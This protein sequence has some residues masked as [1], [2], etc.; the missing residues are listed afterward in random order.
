MKKRYFLLCGMM[1]MMLSISAC[2]GKPQETTAQETI[3]QETKAQETKGAQTT[4]AHD[5]TTAEAPEETEKESTDGEAAEDMDEDTEEESVS[6][7]TKER[8]TKYFDLLLSENGINKDD[9]YVEYGG[10]KYWYDE[11]D[12]LYDAAEEAGGTIDVSLMGEAE[13][14]LDLEI[15][16]NYLDFMSDWDAGSSDESISKELIDRFYG[17]WHGVVRFKDCTGKYADSLGAD[18]DWVTSIARFWIDTDGYVVPF[19]GVHVEDTPIENLE[20]TLDPEDDCMYLSGS[21]INVDFDYVPMTEK[22]GTLHAEIPI[23]KDAGSFTMVFNLRHLNDIGWT[24]EDPALPRDYIENCQGWSF[25]KLAE[26][27]GYTSYDYPSY[28]EGEEPEYPVQ[29]V[30]EEAKQDTGKSTAEADGVVSLST[31]EAAYKWLDGELD[32]SGHDPITYEAVRDHMGVDGKI[33]KSSQWTAEKH[34]YE[35]TT[36]DGKKYLSVTFTVGADGSEIY[37]QMTGSIVQ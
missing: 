36:A 14:M 15:M 1:G 31:L 20:A 5:A 19:I 33:L 27:N 4:A 30:K 23:S 9:F 21:W 6:G 25:D 18:P 22:D 24:D 2:G 10:R 35:W 13:D 37:S 26:S 17:D 11:L 34:R 8:F 3:A 32:K 29:F 12:E 16:S 7:M 28:G